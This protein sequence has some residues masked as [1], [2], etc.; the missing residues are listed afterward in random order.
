MFPQLSFLPMS[1]DIPFFVAIIAAVGILVLIWVCIMAICIVVASFII[2]VVYIICEYI[3]WPLL[4]RCERDIEHGGLVYQSTTSDSTYRHNQSLEGLDGLDG[5][6]GS[7]EESLAQR[8][9]VLEGLLPPVVYGNGEITPSIS[10]DCAICLNDYTG[11][12]TC[13]VFPSCKHV[14]HLNC[15]DY[16]LRNHLTCPVCRHCLID[17]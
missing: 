14:F 11:G 16:W 13:R 15:I 1:P 10:K 12:E 17:P 5:P 7:V 6:P 4:G 3:C 8:R 9:Q 2:V